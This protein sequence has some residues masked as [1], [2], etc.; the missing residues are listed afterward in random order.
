[1]AEIIFPAW[2]PVLL[3]GPWFLDLRWYGLMYVVAFVLGNFILQRLSRAGTL[4][5]NQTRVGDLLFYLILGVILGGRIGWI[6]FYALPAVDS[7][8]DSGWDYFKIWQ[9]GLSFHGGLLGVITV[10]IWFSIKEKASILRIGDCLALATPPGIFA[11]R[12]A[13]FI[14]GELYGRITNESVPW[15]MRFPTDPVAQDVLGG[16]KSGDIRERELVVLKAYD[17]GKWEQVKDQVPLRHPS[18]LYEALAEG[19]VLGLVLWLCYRLF[20]KRLGPGAFMGLFLIGYGSMRFAIEF[21]RQ[22][23][24]LFKQK[25]DPEH[26]GTVLGFLS[27]GQVLC[28]AMLLA[29]VVLLVVAKRGAGKLMEQTEAEVST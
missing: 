29:G 27:M 17:S 1:M 9:G 6:L 4:P 15:A 24:D 3:D 19:V 23:D 13:N 22:P 5:L 8:V 16:V 20:G 25:N 21:F 26:I 14:N 28:M 11:V 18:Q 7:P 2:D 10:L 12:M